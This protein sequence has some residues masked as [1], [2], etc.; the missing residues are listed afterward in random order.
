MTFK[1]PGKSQHSISRC[2]VQA[3]LQKH[4]ETGE[5]ED[6]N[7]RDQPSK[8]SAA[9]TGHIKL[10]SLQNW[11]M[12]ST[13]ISSQMAKRT[14]RFWFTHPHCRE[15]WLEVIFRED[16]QPKSPFSDMETKPRNSLTCAQK[17]KMWDEEKWQTEICGCNSRRQFVHQRARNGWNEERLQA[18]VKDGEGS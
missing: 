10:T 17:H 6:P 11:N 1:T 4:K 16:M 7:H 5:S 18:T 15:I 3:L 13:I 2:A 12:C 9:G 14:V 8:L